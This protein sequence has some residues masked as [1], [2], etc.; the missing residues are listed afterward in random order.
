[1]R[2]NKILAYGV[3]LC[4]LVAGDLAHIVRTVLMIVN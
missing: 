1:M 3:F 4:H 2:K